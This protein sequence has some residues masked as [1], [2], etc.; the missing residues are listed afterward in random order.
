MKLSFEKF[1]YAVGEVIAFCQMIEHDLKVI[2]STLIYGDFDENY[3]SLKTTTLGT[4]INYIEEN[5]LETNL[6]YF[7]KSDYR[8]LKDLTRRRNYVCHEIFLTF[9][10]KKDFINSNEYLL[11]C[12]SL[13]T[14]HSEIV[15]IS[16]KIEQRR[17]YI[18][19][20]G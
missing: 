6:N 17:I 13:L 2:Y 14:F 5:D 18:K 19:K 9:V 3:Q 10:Y 1:K 20:Q 11:A 7:S 8:L 16:K 12:E 4:M 15:E